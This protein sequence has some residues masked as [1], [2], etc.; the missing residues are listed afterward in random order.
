M[1]LLAIYVMSLALL[2]L[3]SVSL[4]QAIA[5]L[6]AAQASRDVQQVFWLAESAVDSAIAHLSTTQD[7]FAYTASI[8]GTAGDAQFTVTPVSGAAASSARMIHATSTSPAGHSTMIT[9]VV[10]E[11]FSFHGVLSEGSI[12]L[13]FMPRGLPGEQSGIVLGDLQSGLG[14]TRS[15]TLSGPVRHQVGLR[16]GSSGPTTE[17]YPTQG[18]GATPWTNVLGTNPNTDGVYLDDSFGAMPTADYILSVA[19]LPSRPLVDAPYSAASCSTPLEWMGGATRIVNDGDPLDLSGPGDGKI[20][21]CL[22]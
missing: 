19:S 5:A 1:L 10:R 6:R 21:L 13:L 20:D 2:V 8:P 18:P 3:E 12:N 7:G 16:I 4:Q 9:A 17:T 11:E 22:S 14:L 15:I